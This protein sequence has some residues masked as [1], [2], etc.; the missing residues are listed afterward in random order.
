MTLDLDLPVEVVGYPIVREADGLAM[1]SRNV[2]LSAAER[3]EALSL[4][5]GLSAARAAWAAGE[6]DARA[7]ERVVAESVSRAPLAA[8]DYIEARDALDLGPV[9]RAERDVVLA[10]AVK[11]GRTRLI[12]NTVLR[13]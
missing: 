13:V 1:S 2:Y 9:D 7:L 4:S 8:V 3:A 11:F 6:R 12:D 5:R 10:V